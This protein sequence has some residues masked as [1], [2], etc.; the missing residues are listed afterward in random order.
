MLLGHVRS[1]RRF[2]EILYKASDLTLAASASAP[3]VISEGFVFAIT[4]ARSTIQMLY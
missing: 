4:F 2:D 3:Q 1:F